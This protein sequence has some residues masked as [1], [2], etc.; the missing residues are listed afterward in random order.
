MRKK[1]LYQ[2]EKYE[3]KNLRTEKKALRQFVPR[4]TSWVQKKVNRE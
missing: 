4:C 2:K 3:R 1:K